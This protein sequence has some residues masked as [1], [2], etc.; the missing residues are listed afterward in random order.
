MR[1]PGRSLTQPHRC[2]YGKSRVGQR[3]KQ[4]ESNLK[5]QEENSHL[6]DKE[7]GLGR[8]Q[9]AHTLVMNFWPPDLGE[10]INAC[11]LNHPARV[12]SYGSL[13]GLIRSHNATQNQIFSR[14]LLS[15]ELSIALTYG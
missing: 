10:K 4:R 7:R 14:A 12:L 13:S 8:N 6:Q 3:Y 11:C 1:S 2:L 9:P 5:T 15:T